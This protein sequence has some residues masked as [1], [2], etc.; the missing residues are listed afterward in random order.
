[1]IETQTGWGIEMNM[2]NKF[3]VID[4][5]TGMI[6]GRFS[7]RKRASNKVDRLDNEYGGYRFHVKEVE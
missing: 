7:T 3:L 1:M 2:S 6:V 4:N 5:Q